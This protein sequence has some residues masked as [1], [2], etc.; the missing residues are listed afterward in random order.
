MVF[1]ED[2]SLLPTSAPSS[3]RAREG[4]TKRMFKCVHITVLLL[5]FCW[6][7]LLSVVTVRNSQPLVFWDFEESQEEVR[8]FF[9]GF[10][11]FLYF[12]VRG[13]RQLVSGQ[14][15]MMEGDIIIRSPNHGNPTSSLDAP[16]ADPNRLWP[17]GMVEYRF[18][19]TFPLEN[20]RKV[21]QA[22][23]YITSKVSCITFHPKTESAVD[24][25][26]IYDGANSCSS[27]LGRVGGDQALRLNR[28]S[29]L[30]KA[31]LG[32]NDF[33]FIF[34]RLFRLWPDNPGP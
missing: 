22:M 34:Q 23:D 28:F 5:I 8:E 6:L 24:F 31:W 3:T 27:E 17:R 19:S 18:Y 29:R 1:K 10:F 14:T 15:S 33:R 30:F 11:T 2:M 12:Q 16:L 13:R 20:R 9:R 7:A 32:K 25:V 4:S 21:V 26:T